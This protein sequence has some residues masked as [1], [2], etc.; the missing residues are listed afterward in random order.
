VHPIPNAVA[1]RPLAFAVSVAERF[2]VPEQRSSE[3]SA[4]HRGCRDTD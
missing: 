1:D 2:S 4:D 3:E